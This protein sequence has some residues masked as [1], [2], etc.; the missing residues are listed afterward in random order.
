MMFEILPFRS[1]AEDIKEMVEQHYEDANELANHEPLNVD[2]D[3]YLEASDA[4][5]CFVFVC[6]DGEEIAGYSIFTINNDANFKDT[7]E[8]TNCG[9]YVKKKYRGRASVELMKISDETMRLMGVNKI[10]YAVKSD[11]VG[12][13]LER[14]GYKQEYKIWSKAA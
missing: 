12:S 7:I 1:V 5:Q 11:K 3:Y 9:L 4:N 13:F 6:K 14:N 2:W 8:A 10:S